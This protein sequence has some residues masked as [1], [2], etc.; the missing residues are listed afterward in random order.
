[1][2]MS[3][4]IFSCFLASAPPATYE[5]SLSDLGL[6]TQSIVEVAPSEAIAKLQAAIVAVRA[7]PH[8]LFRDS[9]AADKLARAQLALV[10]AYLAEG[11]SEAA[12]VTMD[13]IIRDAAGRKLPFAGLGPDVRK[14]HDE[15]RM[16]LEAQGTATIEVDCDGCGVLIG[17][18]KAENPSG[19]LFL[20]VYR[21]W[22]VDP[23]GE[24]E[25]KFM[26]ISLESS[27]QNVSIV[28]RPELLVET[29]NVP[30]PEFGT[31]SS[32][33]P[34]TEPTTTNPKAQRSEPATEPNA[35]RLKIP[36]WAKFLGMGLGASVAVAGGV[37][38][39]LDGKCQG[40][41]AA[42]PDNVAQPNC[43]QVWTNAAPG[44][45]LIG[46]GGGLFVGAGVWLAI[47]ERR[48]WQPPSTSA[49][50][51]WTMRF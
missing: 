24:L 36:R 18:A 33:T 28:Y 26:E 2:M 38:L 21:V 31:H 25:P 6:A 39:A 41:G 14:L 46:I 27:G 16:Q 44:Y 45:A 19:M 12:N 50:L 34:V 32:E 47:D 51:V 10:W 1:M 48:A 43:R 9:M 20:G 4:L 17:D 40:G 3:N 8:E 23:L 5:A 49:T 30:R 11:N 15:R 13:E 35:T 22:V 37:L 7:H 29:E 42:N